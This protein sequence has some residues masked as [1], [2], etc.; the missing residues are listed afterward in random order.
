M[1]IPKQGAIDCDTHLAMPPVRALLPFMSDYWRDQIV[2]RFIDRS[3]F[4]MTSYPTHSP[5][6]GR[7]DWRREAGSGALPGG[8]LDL[9]RRQLLDPFGLAIAVCH[10]FHGAVALFNEDMGAE[11]CAAMNRW[12]A[13]QWLDR[14]PRLRA[15]ILVHAQNPQLAVE[16]I[17]RCA[18]DRRFVAVLLPAMGD[19]LLG[20]RI[21]WPIYEAAERHGLSLAVHAGST[22]RHPP[23]GVGW[24]S[25]QIEDYISQSAAFQNLIISFL[26]EGVFQKFPELTLVCLE[27]GFTWMPTLLWRA[28]KTWRGVRTEVPWIDRNPAH[29]VRERV[30]LSLRPFDAP[31]EPAIIARI[32]EQIDCPDMMVFSTD[33]PH[34]HFEGLEALP[35]GLAPALIDKILFDNP[36]AAFPR[37][38]AQTAKANMQ[39]TEAT[40]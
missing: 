11:F 12:V 15:S 17:E 24:T 36:L 8:T 31:R 37:L 10:P 13:A 9:L 35:D 22:Y 26:A 16:E 5:L 39:A 1:K 14:E 30:K 33:Y 25:Y 20:R 3:S 4:A 21:Y 18:G 23:T 32:F 19:N 40:P 27:S 34:W 38:A 6:T 7:E 29:I 2:N 28:A